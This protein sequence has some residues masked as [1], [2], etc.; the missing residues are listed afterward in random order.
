MT[1]I[2]RPESDNFFGALR[3]LSSDYSRKWTLIFTRRRRARQSKEAM[4]LFEIC[5]IASLV[6][7]FGSTLLMSAGVHCALRRPSHHTNA[8]I[9]MLQQL[10]PIHARNELEQI[11]HPGFQLSDPDRLSVV[12][13]GTT[14]PDTIQVPRF[15]DP[16]AY[17]GIRQFLGNHGQ[18]LIT[19][20]EASTIGSM[21]QGHETVFVL[22][23]S[24]RDPECRPTVEDI[25]L[26]AKHPERIRVAIIDQRSPGDEDP[27]C[28]KP[29]QTCGENPR[30]A[31]CRYS[32]LIDYLE[33]EAQLMVGPTFARHLGNR[34]YRGEYFTMQVDSHVR[35]VADWDEDIIDQWKSIGN[36]MAVL[37]TY[38]NDIKN[39][40]DPETHQSVRESRSIMCH[41]EFEWKG[42]SKEHIKYNIQPTNKPRIKSSPMLHPFWAAGFSFARGHFAIQVRY[43]PHLP[44]G[45]FW[46]KNSVHRHLSQHSLF[47]SISL[48]R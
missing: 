14:F 10:F 47:P 38:L 2:K 39:S 34:M 27:T 1:Q 30:Q 23:A 22:V 11:N 4:Q 19:K 8:D 6:F 42:D 24:Y 35:F 7:F 3:M 28:G 45:T 41:A 46:D 33:Y 36:E 18:H 44:F 21:Y 48:S 43:D 26:R 12:L 16:P 40:I 31:F 15:W 25:F 32:H 29:A 9:E 37:S 17:G 20:E 13:D 5:C